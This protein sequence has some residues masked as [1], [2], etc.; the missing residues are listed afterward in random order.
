M[1]YRKVWECLFQTILHCCCVFTTSVQNGT[2]NPGYT[3]TNFITPR[4]VG[5][6]PNR[7]VAHNMVC[8][9]VYVCVCVERERG[10]SSK[11][12]ASLFSKTLLKM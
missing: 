3:L 4:E 8:V 1:I 12:D 11:F 7:L 2:F 10:M 5:G 9:C 6:C